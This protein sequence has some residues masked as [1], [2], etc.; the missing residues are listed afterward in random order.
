MVSGSNSMSAGDAKHSPRS[1]ALTN[2]RSASRS[3]STARS[4]TSPRR[5]RHQ[6]HPVHDLVTETVVGERPDLLRRP[7]LSCLRHAHKLLGSA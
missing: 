4:C 3:S 5:R 6:V 7:D 2:G 1:Q